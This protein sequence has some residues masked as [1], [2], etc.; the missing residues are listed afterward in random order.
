ML[1]D[2]YFL[3]TIDALSAD[4]EHAEYFQSLLHENNYRDQTAITP[5]Y[6]RDINSTCIIVISFDAFCVLRY[7]RTYSKSLNKE[8]PFFMFGREEK[9]G[10]VYFDEVQFSKDNLLTDFADFRQLTYGIDDAM[11]DYIQKNSAECLL[12]ESGHSA[13]P[14]YKRA[15]RCYGHTH[16]VKGG[17]DR[18]SF[19][20]LQCTVEHALINRFFSSDEM[21]SMDV[22]ITPSGDL[23]FIMYEKNKMFEGFYK[24]RWVYVQMKDGNFRRI[25][26]Y[27]NGR[28]KPHPLMI[29][30]KKTNFQQRA[31]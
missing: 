5:Y 21:G 29:D 13:I 10:I 26:S 7:I 4:A 18:F 1:V 6:I 28:Y 11:D 20:D 3:K 22:L 27:K 23:N 30:I 9:H 12:D 8:V 15:V 25:S 24:Y 19:A 17:G 31:V 16:P 2:K 14:K